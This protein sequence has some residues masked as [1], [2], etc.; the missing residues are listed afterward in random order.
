MTSLGAKMISHPS[1]ISNYIRHGWKLVPIPFGSKGP[2]TSGWNTEDKCL[3]S[4]AD[5]PPNWGVGLAHA[6]SGTMALDI[7]A[8]DHAEAEL[9]KHGISLID[10]YS[11]PD[12]V[13]ID[14]GKHG[15]GKLIYKMPFGL[16]LPSKKLITT[17]NGSRI[18]Y[19]DFRCSTSNGLTVQDVI[20]PSI[21]PETLQP[22]RWA[23]KGSWM[24]LPTIPQPLL[25]FWMSLI[26]EDT[27]KDI[28]D[29]SIT[30]SWSEI[31]TVLYHISPDCDRE[32]WVHVGM[33]LHHAGYQDKSLD[34]AFMLWQDWS[35]QSETK[36]KGAKDLMR[37]WRSFQPNNGITIGTLFHIAKEHGYERPRPSAEELFSAVP[38]D[39]KEDGRIIPVSYSDIIKGYSPISP[40][41]DL[42]LFPEVLAT[43][44]KEVA[45]SIG[46]DPLVPLFA[47]LA[48]AAGAANA[49][50]RL[51]LMPG[52]KV[53]PILWLMTIG[54]PADKKTPGADPMMTILEQLEKEDTPRYKQ[55]LIDFEAQEIMYTANRKRFEDYYK[56]DE[57]ILGEHDTLPDAP[58][59]PVRLKIKVQDITSQKL[60][61]DAADRPE[62]LICHL[63]EMSNWI[64]IICDKRSG[65]NRSAWTVAYEAKR[66][67]M[68]RVGAG[69]IICDNFSVSIFGNVQPRIFRS[70]M[71]DLGEDG[72]MQRFIPIMLDTKKTKRGN[73]MPEYMTTASRWE[74][75]IRVIHALPETDYHLSHDAYEAFREFQ[76]W[77]EDAKQDFVKLNFS[78]TFMTAYGKLEGTAGRLIMV[79]HLL[80]NPFNTTVSKET[81]NNVVQL[82]KSYIIPCYRYSYDHIVGDDEQGNFEMWLFDYI[83]YHSERE[84]EIDTVKIRNA[85]RRKFS[86]RMNRFEKTERISTAMTAL[87]LTNWVIRI[88]EYDRK[89]V[90]KW[91]I[92]P[93]IFPMFKQERH[94]IVKKRQKWKDMICD[95]AGVPRQQVDANTEE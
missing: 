57:A 94:E 91:A 73:P 25:D 31:Q 60:V 20:P 11:N 74:N 75:A 52:Y 64:K 89:N 70:A 79:F 2:I 65:D 54:R 77:Y 8:W 45:D 59:P 58:N 68:D 39:D 95:T 41:P 48:T 35:S 17:E 62:G 47:G 63:D 53:P 86:E 22:Y 18:N 7:D 3:T 21:H 55:A 84:S 23:G 12:A 46:C 81:V 14:S 72:L 4:Q 42:S 44:A 56:S 51:E 76:S 50:S 5:L 92:N 90:I 30:T 83:L 40:S 85:A 9:Q 16:T 49:L 19:L 26:E 82:V 71:K 43:R 15:H 36:Y 24:H 33:A 6:Y 13:I 93:L 87:E 38:S 37:S 67:L 80:E 69:S 88:E 28:V 32:Q 10:L 27:H 78:E 34:T 61:R 29:K 1:N 66:Y